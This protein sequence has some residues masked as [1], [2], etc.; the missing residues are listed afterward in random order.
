MGNNNTKQ[1]NENNIQTYIENDT[2]YV[3]NIKKDDKIIENKDDKIIENKDDKIIENKDDKIIEKIDKKIIEKDDKDDK[4]DEKDDKI[5]ENKVPKIAKWEESRWLVLSSGFLMIPAIY[6]YSKKLYSHSTLLLLTS[7]VS[8]NFWRN[9]T[10]SWRRTTDLI[11]SKITFAVFFYIGT[12]IRYI[13]Y[14]A[15]GYPGLVTLSYCFYLSG[16]L[17]ELKNKNWWKYHMTF[18][19]LLAFELMLIIDAGL[20]FTSTKS[21]CNR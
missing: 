15:I 19:A 13:P 11:L 16:K 10:Y 8:M 12:Y 18:H 1:E 20:G 14:I 21:L 4:I 5:I 9:A 17:W 3:T 7:L 6:G 2:I